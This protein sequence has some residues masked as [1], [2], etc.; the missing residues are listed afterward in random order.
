MKGRGEPDA[1]VAHARARRFSQR[2]IRPRLFA[3]KATGGIRAPRVTL[4]LRCPGR[5]G[6]VTLR[7]AGRN[8]RGTANNAV[9]IRILVTLRRLELDVLQTQTRRG[10]LMR[11]R[12]RQRFRAP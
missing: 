9:N 8:T 4:G 10:G 2:S 1:P 7:A 11:A 5:N 3:C 6:F 12:V